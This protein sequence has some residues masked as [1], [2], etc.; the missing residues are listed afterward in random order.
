MIND[1]ED[2]NL[3]KEEAAIKEDLVRYEKALNFLLKRDWNEEFDR[4]FGAFSL[5]NDDDGNNSRGIEK[6]RIEDLEKYKEFIEFLRK[7]EKELKEDDEK[8]QDEKF[9]G[10]LSDVKSEDN[11]NEASLKDV[12]DFIKSAISLFDTR[13]EEYQA[14]NE[15]TLEE[16]EEKKRLLTMVEFF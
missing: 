2:S 9:A 1:L 5:L 12:I 16:A 11:K 7:Q 6:V 8:V 10:T 14:I 13:Y 3:C 4:L 15:L